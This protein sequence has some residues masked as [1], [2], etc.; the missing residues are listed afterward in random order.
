M[1]ILILLCF[2]QYATG[3]ILTK[4]LLYSVNPERFQESYK[5]LP[6]FSWLG[7]LFILMLY[8]QDK[9]HNVIDSNYGY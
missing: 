2:L 1:I 9:Y 4:T 5:Y 8:I 6:F 3:W 7:T